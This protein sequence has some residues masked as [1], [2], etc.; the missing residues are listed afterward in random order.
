[1]T[2][3]SVDQLVHPLVLAASARYSP[4]KYSA[5]G[6]ATNRP[7]DDQR[8]RQHRGHPAVQHGE[9]RAGVA[10]GGSVRSASVTGAPSARKIGAIIDSSMCWTMWT[11]SSACRTRP[12]RSPWPTAIEPRP[13]QERDGPP[14]R[15]A[16]AAR[17]RSR[18]TPHEV[19]RRP[20]RAG[21]APTQRQRVGLGEQR[22]RGE[23][24]RASA[25]VGQTPCVTPAE[26]SRTGARPSG[27]P[28]PRH[29]RRPPIRTR[30]F[31]A[32]DTRLRHPGRARPAITGNNDRVTA[33][34]ALP[35]SQIHSLTRPNM[36]SVGTIVWLSSELMFFAAL[37]AMYFS[38]RATAV[39]QEEW[40]EHTQVLNLPVRADVHDRSWCSRRS[41]ASSA[42]S[43]PSGATCTGC[44][45][46][47]R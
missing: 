34:Q 25:A 43:G 18:T 1:M 27:G 41:P 22:G 8:E 46:G 36:V 11:E 45:G 12:G 15:P 26:A 31:S 37:F 7:N 28:V 17:R 16:V 35:K 40:A 21:R 10:R 4:E 19:Q 30:L 39:G 33:A 47:S 42:C 44:G 6:L 2:K 9:Q 3:C 38:I 5:N 23:R 13:S 14:D 29:R 24:G 20:R 32:H